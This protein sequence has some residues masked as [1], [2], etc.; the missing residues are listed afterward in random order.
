MPSPGRDRGPN[1]PIWAFI[2]CDLIDPAEAATFNRWYNDEH[3]PRYVR[4]P[5]FRRAWRL[6]RL[7][8]PE[9]RGTPH[10]RYL[11]V[12]ETETVADFNDVLRRDAE[13]S[14]PWE[15]WESRITGWQRTYYGVIAR[16]GADRPA[17]GGGSH[18]TIVRVDFEEAGAGDEADFNRWYDETHLPEVCA[19]PGFRRAWRLRLEPDGNDLGPRGQ[20]YVAV[21]ETD[22][23][24]YL[25]VARRGTVP[26]DGKWAG[27]IRNWE[28]MFYRKLFDSEAQ[29]RSGAETRT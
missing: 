4:Q 15:G 23:A 20:R 29:A 13:D 14:H 9:Q 7:D 5:G 2:R 18:W 16:Y 22:A 24:D 25:P 11:A 21:Y 17:D 10:Q 28:A 27:S 19:F 3:A 1:V 26:W 6:E 12:Y 8:L